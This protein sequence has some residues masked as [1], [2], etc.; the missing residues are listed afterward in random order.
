MYIQ[1]KVLYS[2]IIVPNIFEDR[3]SNGKLYRYIPGIYIV[4]GFCAFGSAALL[5]QLCDMLRLH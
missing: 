2:V 3:D 1:L 5:K 4:F